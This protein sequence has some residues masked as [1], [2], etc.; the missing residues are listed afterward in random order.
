MQTFSCLW[1]LAACSLPHSRGK[2][3]AFLS[4]RNLSA[5]TNGL[6]R[7]RR[8]GRG[9][10][11]AMQISVPT[12]N[13]E[14]LLTVVVAFFCPSELSLGIPGSGKEHHRPGGGAR[15]LGIVWFM[16]GGSP[17]VSSRT[18]MWSRFAAWLSLECRRVKKAVGQVPGAGQ[19]RVLA[20]DAGFLI[21]ALWVNVRV[22]CLIRR[23]A[24]GLSG[25][26]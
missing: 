26:A 8:R 5:C 19:R 20:P 7:D 14:R 2:G 16:F 1:G 9:A 22:P 3:Y 25:F 13:S 12:S 18:T 23:R 17:G 24:P 11:H 10:A 21:E 15:C 6:D 4:A